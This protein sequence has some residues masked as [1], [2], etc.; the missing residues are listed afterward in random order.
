M[1]AD[2][3]AT[4]V[5]KDEADETNAITPAAAA[6]TTAAAEAEAEAATDAANKREEDR[7][8]PVDVCVDYVSKF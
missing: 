4:D 5:P 8:M 7:R 2:T 6:A 3:A 1:H